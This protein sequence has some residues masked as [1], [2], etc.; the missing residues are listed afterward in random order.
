[1]SEFNEIVSLVQDWTRLTCT[2]K[3]N[4]EYN[5][6]KVKKVIFN[7]PT[8][9]ILWEDGDK[10]VVRCGKND[11]FDEDE[12]FAV[13]FIKKVFGTRRAYQRIIEKAD[14]QPK[15]NVKK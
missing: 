3:S 9:I 4:P 12:G 13:A 11:V 2:Y 5:Y 8:T 7:P 1:M 14:R 15:E 10:T 6:P